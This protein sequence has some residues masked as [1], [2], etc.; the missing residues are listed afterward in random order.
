MKHVLISITHGNLS[1]H[2]NQPFSLRVDYFKGIK[3][4]NLKNLP[5]IHHLLNG[6]DLHWD[7]DLAQI[8]VK[9]IALES[10]TNPRGTV[11]GGMI[12]AMLDD[13]MGILAALNKT[14]KPAT[15][16]NLSIDF[17]RPCHVGNVETKAW[18][19]KQGSKI[20]NIESEA[21]QQGK[22]IAKCSSAFLVL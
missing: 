20:L 21:W 17:L 11:E 14:E 16:V 18:F 7:K 12:C 1:N 10:F 5:P 9:Y 15:T 4:F 22:L 6:H 13:A 3:M 8:H 2:F 19:I